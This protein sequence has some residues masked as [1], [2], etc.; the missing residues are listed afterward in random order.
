MT[1]VM[2]WLMFPKDFFPHELRSTY[3]QLESFIRSQTKVLL[4]ADLQFC[5]QLKLVHQ[6]NAFI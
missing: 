6:A 3:V 1:I 2:Y 4:S 5:F